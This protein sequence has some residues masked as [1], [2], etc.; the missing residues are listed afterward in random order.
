MSTKIYLFPDTNLFIQCKPLGELDWSK[1]EEYDE[2]CLLVSRPVQAEIDR[3]KGGGNS[4]LAKRARST[5]SRFGDILLSE[6][7][8]Y[9]VRNAKPIVRLYLRQDIKPDE[10]LSDRLM[11][12]ERDDQ[13]VGIAA[14]FSKDH[15]ENT[16]FILTH[17][18]GPMASAKM[19]GV[20]FNKIP[21]EWLLAP[22]TSE[23]DKKIG[24][25]QAELTRLKKTEP[26][27]EI[28]F[29]NE[30]TGDTDFNI[31]MDVYSALTED[32]ISS[33]LEH[34]TSAIPPESEFGSK[35]AD[36]NEFTGLNNFASLSAILGKR[37]FTPATDE[38]I[39]SYKDV[40]YPAWIQSCE[41]YLRDLHNHLNKSTN[42]PEATA[43]ISNTGTRPAEDA[44]V[45]LVAHG[46]FLTLPP[47]EDE[48][49]NKLKKPALPMPPEAPQGRLETIKSP[50]QQFN[51]PY[52]VMPFSDLDEL[53]STLS[54]INHRGRDSNAFYY[55]ERPEN[56][57][58]SFS[59]TCKQW[60]H[61]D[62]EEPFQ[63]ILC[64]ERSPGK[65]SGA[66]EVK[67]QAANMADPV[68]RHESISIKVTD[69]SA[70]ERAEQLVKS[71]IRNATAHRRAPLD[72]RVKR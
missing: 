67:V 15:P 58:K 72:I 64:F 69:I 26:N 36:E 68:V 12:N 57:V 41:E 35:E 10:S 33:L 38:D 56:P 2:V 40:H 18:I 4:R 25:L 59:L 5:S 49:I 27:I 46:N 20:K 1:W 37:T 19:V 29:E 61:Q 66:L 24:Q 39:T 28:R 30:A 3:Q 22:E 8:Y 6:K 62:E 9:E 60:R 23:S 55:H 45:T 16:V 32:Q 53:A 63:A 7:D 31:E 65:I 48:E 34:I 17:D 51:R 47:K 14:K 43:W 44:L 71:L 54:H 50:F 21:D 70:F 11:Y 52:S 13:L 42:F